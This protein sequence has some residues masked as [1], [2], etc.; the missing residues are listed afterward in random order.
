[1]RGAIRN[2]SCE[3]E[4]LRQEAEDEGEEYD[5]DYENSLPM[6]DRRI[7]E[8]SYV[9]HSYECERRWETG[10]RDAFAPDPEDTITSPSD[11]SEFMLAFDM[12]VGGKASSIGK[13]KHEYAL[14]S[15][16][17]PITVEDD[18]VKMTTGPAILRHDMDE[19]KLRSYGQDAM[20]AEIRICRYCSPEARQTWQDR[21]IG[22]FRI[23]KF[24]GRRTSDQMPT[25][26]SVAGMC[27]YEHQA[28]DWW[29]G[30]DVKFAFTVS[31]DPEFCNL[32]WGVSPEFQPSLPPPLPPYV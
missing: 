1:M 11:H 23:G 2:C 29:Y 16:L 9:E 18:I 5:S 30:S 32:Q 13:Q 26:F 19:Q 17:L 24:C 14:L 15:A 28:A 7:I 22:T 4:V 20:S 10:I 25:E 12:Q 27:S 6:A 21:P 31:E 3:K 8:D